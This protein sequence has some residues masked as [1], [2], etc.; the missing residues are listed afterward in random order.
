MLAQFKVLTIA[1]FSLMLCVACGKKEDAAAPASTPVAEAPAGMSA[2]PPAGSPAE[3]GA[4]C[5]G[6]A[7]VQC[8][9]A[10][11]YCAKAEN[12]CGVADA[13]GTCTAKPTACTLEFKPVCG[14]DGKTY[15]NACAAA[16]KGVNVAK[17][18]AC[19]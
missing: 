7:D 2:A 19:T 5:G 6:Q 15:N 18:A 10:T 12:S 13:P 3:T 1:A 8:K 4:I 16:V 9:N 14:C 11:D 17:S